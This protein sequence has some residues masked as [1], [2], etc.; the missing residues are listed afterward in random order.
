MILLVVNI[1]CQVTFASTCVYVVHV[2]YNHRKQAVYQVPEELLALVVL[3][4]GIVK[5]LN[6]ASSLEPD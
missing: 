2:S 1:E 5:E 4:A 6:C 3:K